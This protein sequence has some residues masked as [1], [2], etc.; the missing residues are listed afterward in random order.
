MVRRLAAGERV[1]RERLFLSFTRHNP[2]IITSGP[3]GLNGSIKGAGFVPREEY[4]HEFLQTFLSHI[5]AGWRKGYAEQGLALLA[6]M[7]YGEE[8]RKRLDFAKLG[9]LELARGHTWVNILHEPRATLLFYE[10]PSVSYEVRCRVEIHREGLYHA[11]INAMHDVYHRPD[12]S[13]W[14]ERPAYIFVIEEIYDNSAGPRGF[15][16]KIYPV[17]RDA[18][19]E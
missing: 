7:V 19:G 6:Q 9:S 3:G 1:P 15:G 4:A 16:R 12:P 8:G 13:R 17:E 14:P 11:L 2:A 5:N 18:R 10:P